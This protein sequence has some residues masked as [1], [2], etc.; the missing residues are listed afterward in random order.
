MFDGPPGYSFKMSISIDPGLNEPYIW[1]TKKHGQTS[2]GNAMEDAVVYIPKYV[3]MN[4]AAMVSAKEDIILKWS[5]FGTTVQDLFCVMR[6][7]IKLVS[8]SRYYSEVIME[9]QAPVEGAPMTVEP[10]VP[11]GEAPEGVAVKFTGGEKCIEIKRMYKVT[12]TKGKDDSLI[13]QA[14][15][16]EKI[17]VFD[18]CLAGVA[19]EIPIAEE[20]SEELSH[21]RETPA[22]LTEHSHTM[23]LS[24]AASS[25]QPSIQ[26][27]EVSSRPLS[28]VSGQ[29]SSALPSQV[30]SKQESSPL[31]SGIPRKKKIPEEWRLSALLK[32]QVK[33]PPISGAPEEGPKSAGLSELKS[34][35]P[36][37]EG[38]KD[39]ETRQAL[40]ISTLP[41]NQSSP[42]GADIRASEVSPQQAASSPPASM[43]DR[44]GSQVVN[45]SGATGGDS[46][47]TPASG[48][49]Q[50]LKDY[51][52]IPFY[53]T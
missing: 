19:E 16:K 22:L 32:K 38:E 25:E 6:L 37:A 27:S 46:S 53:S 12:V 42:I 28:S 34:A 2:G 49:L 17:L 33:L 18:A 11:E 45:A 7:K 29:E 5:F 51:W 9:K 20:M 47:G 23:P 36:A 4:T 8:G 14:R 41:D 52:E 10:I 31:A 50:N 3:C 43:P 13:R 35:P 30:T 21:H 15:R 44:V 24:A 1:K 39:T 40:P 48:N 26:I